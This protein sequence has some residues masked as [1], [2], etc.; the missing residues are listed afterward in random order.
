MTNTG[1][2]YTKEVDELVKITTYRMRTFEGKGGGDVKMKYRAFSQSDASYKDI[3]PERRQFVDILP[4]R[5][6]IVGYSPRAT[7][8]C[9]YSPRATLVC[10]YSPRATLDSR[11]F[12]QS[13]ALIRHNIDARSMR[14]RSRAMI[15][16]TS[17][18]PIRPLVESR[19]TVQ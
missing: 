3:L 16:N 2:N 8:V 18:T 10:R 1:R 19:S 4:E 14:C 12:S 13:D 5:R 11:I 6:L 15:P 17:Q 7:L 9:G